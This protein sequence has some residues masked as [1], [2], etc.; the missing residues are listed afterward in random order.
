MKY[1]GLS[2]DYAR[3]GIFFAVAAV[4]VT[5]FYDATIPSAKTAVTYTW[6]VSQVPGE[7]PRADFDMSELQ[8]EL[9]HPSFKERARLRADATNFRDAGRDDF[10]YG[11]DTPCFKVEIDESVSGTD[12]QPDMFR[13]ESYLSTSELFRSGLETAMAESF[14]EEVWARD[15]KCFNGSFVISFDVDEEGRIGKNMLVHHVK[16]SSNAAG[17]AVLDVL[18]SMDLDGHRWHDG[19]AGEVEVRVPVKFKL[20]S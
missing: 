14:T 17:I 10:Y 6:D 3:V 1:F 5:L 18:R 7:R 20:E 15:S 2:S 16:G 13:G 12:F 19:S 8:P 11:S 9:Q 4:A